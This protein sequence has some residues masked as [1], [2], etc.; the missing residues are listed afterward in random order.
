MGILGTNTTISTT[1]HQM[2]V[3]VDDDVEKNRT[4][5]STSSVSRKSRPTPELLQQQQRKQQTRKGRSFHAPRRHTED[6]L[7][8]TKI[9]ASIGEDPFFYELRQSQKQKMQCHATNSSCP[10]H[11]SFK[12]VPTD[13]EEVCTVPFSQRQQQPSS[14]SDDLPSDVFQKTKTISCES[15]NSSRLD[16]DSSEN[17]NKS[18]LIVES[19][20]SA[21]LIE[22]ELFALVSL[23]FQLVQEAEF[24]DSLC[25]E[26]STVATKDTETT[27]T[28]TTSNNEEMHF[29]RNRV[30]QLEQENLRLLNEVATWKQ[31]A[32]SASSTVGEEKQIADVKVSSSF[33]SRT[34]PQQQQQL[35]SSC[36]LPSTH[37]VEDYVMD[38][39]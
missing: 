35:W 11:D 26:N 15:Q 34:P 24:D 38:D 1:I 16:D 18:N 33:S 10:S 36:F 17:N 25:S 29:M 32:T 39:G 23:G 12:S 27:I 20:H 30:Q 8:P 13:E 21:E 5:A 6:L 4:I 9:N 2:F 7:S 14:S 28:E 19:S 3:R 37:N 31:V 22:N